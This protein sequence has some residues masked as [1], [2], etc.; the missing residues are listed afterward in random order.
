MHEHGILYFLKTSLLPT[1]RWA[2]NGSVLAVRLMAKVLHVLSCALSIVVRYLHDLLSHFFQVHTQI[3]PKP[4]ASP[5][6]YLPDFTMLPSRLSYLTGRSFAC[7]L[8]CYLFP[9]TVSSNTAE[10]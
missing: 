10:P 5:H 9:Y 3:S 4:G 6:S 7:L 2:E 8:V 1:T